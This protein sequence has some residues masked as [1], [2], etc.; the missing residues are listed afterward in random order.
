MAVQERGQPRAERLYC[1][2]H[3]HR[4]AAKHS[5]QHANDREVFGTPIYPHQAV[6]F[7]LTEEYAR[8]EKAA[9]MRRKAAWL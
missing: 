1:V 9:L 7:S 5:I 3:W 6:S 2:R 8:I 4:Q